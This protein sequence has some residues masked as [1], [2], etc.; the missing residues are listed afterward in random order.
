VISAN[1]SQYGKKRWQDGTLQPLEG[2]AAQ[3][4]MQVATRYGA[5]VGAPGLVGQFF[6]STSGSAPRDSSGWSR[7][8]LSRAVEGHQRAKTTRPELPVSCR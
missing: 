1:T 6:P 7:Q 8:N 5:R 2:S 4:V 3:S